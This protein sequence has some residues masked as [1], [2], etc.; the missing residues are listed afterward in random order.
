[1]WEE[2]DLSVE[3][4]DFEKLSRYLGN[5][6]KREEIVEEGFEKL[7]YKKRSQGKEKEDSY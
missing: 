7:V 3:G 5:Y 6:L 4:V 2:S 1:M